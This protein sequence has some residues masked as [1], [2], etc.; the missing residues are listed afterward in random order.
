MKII[1]VLLC[2]V[3]LI[4]ICP[5]YSEDLISITVQWEANV[6]DWGISGYKV[7]YGTPV[8]NYDQIVDVGTNTTYTIEDLIPRTTYSFYSTCYTSNGVES[9]PS[10]KVIWNSGKPMRDIPSIIPNRNRKR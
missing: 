4:L 1:Y 10:N 3:L 8:G 2:C 9:L 6:T 5:T 7:Y